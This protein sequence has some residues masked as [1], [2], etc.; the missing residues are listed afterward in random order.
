[1]LNGSPIDPERLGA[2]LD[3]RVKGRERDELLA[4]LAASDEGLE[5]FADAL[6]VHDELRDEDARA[7]EAADDPRVVPFRR[8]VRRAAWG[9]GPRLALAAALAAAA[10]G[11]ATWGLDRGR[12]GADDPGRYAA[13][14]GAPGLPAGWEASPWTAARAAGETLDPRARAVRVGARITDLEA[15]AAAGDPAGARQA[16]AEVG[17]L[18]G[19]LPAAGPAASV[20]DEIGRRAGEPAAALAPLREQGRRTAAAL[21]GEEGVALGAWAEAAR[22]AAARRDQRFFRAHATR[23]ALQAAAGDAALPPSAR[24]AVEGIRAALAASG[25]PDWDTVE[26]EAARLLAAAGG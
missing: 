7:A 11:I 25:A 26:R 9:R 21:A 15:A 1:V 14:L 10:L 23:R 8:P 5:A 2:L 6:A 13:L 17:A 24:S 18:L 3:G 19:D 22:L 12:G 4:R 20:Y 16:A